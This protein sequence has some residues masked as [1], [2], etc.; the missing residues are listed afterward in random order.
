MYCKEREGLITCEPN[1]NF[2]NIPNTWIITNKWCETM[3]IDRVQ[4]HHLTLVKYTE[5]GQDYKSSA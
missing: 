4:F 2:N 5:S 1:I 3:P